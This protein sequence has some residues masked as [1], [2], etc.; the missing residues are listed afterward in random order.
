MNLSIY[1]FSLIS[2][3]LSFDEHRQQIEIVINEELP[4]ST[5][6]FM[7]NENL[8]YRFFDSVRNQNSFV[9]FQP[10]TGHLILDRTI[11]REQLCFD[12]ICSCSRCQ[13]L[14]ELIEW[15]PPYRLLKLIL[16][17][18]DIN[19][20]S[21]KFPSDF[22]RFNVMENVDLGFELSLEQAQDID[23]GENARLS[24]VLESF[25]ADPLTHRPFELLLKPNGALILKVNE[26]LDREQRD[27]YEYRLIA[28]DHGQPKRFA[29]TK[30]TV[31]IEVSFLMTI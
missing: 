1:L 26:N 8:T 10:S 13:L 6:L 11:D 5:I 3:V 20:N 22:Y 27:S 17:V 15:Q 28:Y 4:L 23:L 9:T 24:Y 19:D 25:D 16:I 29:T 30:I 14:I 31:D 7:T 21:P 12:R 2:L 18:E